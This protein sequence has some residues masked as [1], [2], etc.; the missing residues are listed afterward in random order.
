[1]KTIRVGSRESKLAVI[2]SELV[3]DAIRAS[4]PDIALELVTMKTTGDKIL[5]RTLDKIG[6]KGLFVKEL[7]AA[8]LDGRADLTVHSCKDLPMDVDPRIPLA[9]FSKRE[10]PRDVLVLPQGAAELDHT[11][12][13]GCASARR[14]VQLKELF[15]GVDIAP[16]RGNVL[17]RLR[18]LDEGGYSALVLAAAGLKRLGLENRITRYFTV[19]EMIPAAGQGILAIQSRAGEDLSYLSHVV[20]EEGTL[21]ASAE[22]AFVRRLDGGC[23]SP[24]AAH[25]RIKNEE[26]SIT[27]LYVDEAGRVL[28]R[29]VTGPRDRGEALAIALADEMKGGVSCPEK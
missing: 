21:C 12:P 26:I 1:M 23:S 14:A 7:D 10:D 2:Q 17:T 18:K 29:T 28:R 16:V 3:M 8:L 4:H 27:G 9:G 19:D 13:I 20:D 5:D 11:K 25:A 15:P 24:I 6:G 22:R